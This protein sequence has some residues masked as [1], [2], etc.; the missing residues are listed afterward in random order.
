MKN[1]ISLENIAL[2]FHQTFVN[3]ISFIAQ[4]YPT[5]L[6]SGGCFQNAILTKLTLKALKGKKIFLNGEIPCNDGG[7][8]FGQAYYMRLK[9]KQKP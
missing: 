4:K 6:L 3:I 7:I 9:T 8:S 2:N 1:H 5:I